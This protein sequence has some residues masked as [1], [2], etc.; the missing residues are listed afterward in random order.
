M[1]LIVS[2]PPFVKRGMTTEK[3]QWAVVAALA[4]IMAVSIHIFGVR[5]LA[6]LGVSIGSAIVTEIACRL[7]AGKEVRMMDSSA[8]ITGI[9]LALLV[10][11]QAPLWIPM[12]SAIFAIGIVKEAFGG[13]G[14][15]I[16][17]PALAGGVFIMM[18][19]AVHTVAVPGPVQ[20]LAVIQ[21]QAV[22][23]IETSPVA[24]V[25]PA[26]FLMAFKCMDWR[27][28][29]SYL[30]FTLAFAFL[31]QQDYSFVF[32]GIYALGVFFFVTDPVTTPVTKKGRVL[33]GI[34]C[35][36]LTVLYAKFA[37][38]VEGLG[39]SILLM[40]AVTPLLDRFTIPKPTV[41]KN[42]YEDL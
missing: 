34:G 7:V 28:P 39:L 16:F 37:C 40:N 9:L 27:V 20:P 31:L 25:I 14:N 41:V 3:I 2:A 19:W 11:S 13:N 17:N 5:A 22:R 10:P 6:I 1:K 12:V 18:A 24:L 32:S 36:F 23:L 35:G 26:L 33:F 21:D 42:I 15:N 8:V 4:P 38:F 29:F 30:A